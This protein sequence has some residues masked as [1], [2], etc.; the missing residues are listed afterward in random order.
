[1]D[2][3][4]DYWM[5]GRKDR[6]YYSTLN[7]LI[8]FAAGRTTT[9]EELEDM[10]ESGNPAIFSSGVSRLSLCLGIWPVFSL[11]TL[12]RVDPKVPFQKAVGQPH[13]SRKKSSDIPRKRPKHH[14]LAG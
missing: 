8:S 4:L 9:S 10:L 12:L 2:K 1:M 6:F 7:F 3:V 14:H 11:S 5:L 13:G